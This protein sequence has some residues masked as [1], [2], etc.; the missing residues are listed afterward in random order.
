MKSKPFR[1]PWGLNKCRMELRHRRYE[2]F[3]EPRMFTRSCMTERFFNTNIARF[4]D[5]W[6]KQ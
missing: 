2:R 4:T 1:S 3:L 5:I 6:S